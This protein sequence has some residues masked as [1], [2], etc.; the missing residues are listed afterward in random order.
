[1]FRAIK[2]SILKLKLAFA[3]ENMCMMYVCACVHVSA[4]A[5]VC[6]YGC[7]GLIQELFIFSINSELSDG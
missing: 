1:M 7:Q 2:Y 4:C 6:L 5:L 3:Y